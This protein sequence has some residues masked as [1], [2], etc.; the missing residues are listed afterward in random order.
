MVVIPNCLTHHTA[1]WKEIDL[2]SAHGVNEEI[3]THIRLNQ[4]W[5]LRNPN[6]WVN[7]CSPF[8]WVPTPGRTIGT[9]E[10]ALNVF[11]AR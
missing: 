4:G 7:S 2:W 9:W 11:S 8:F 5:H 1:V 3:P 6:D 10:V